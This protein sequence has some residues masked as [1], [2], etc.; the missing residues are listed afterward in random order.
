[1]YFIDYFCFVLD[2][3]EYKQHQDVIADIPYL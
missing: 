2:A 1:M 3:E